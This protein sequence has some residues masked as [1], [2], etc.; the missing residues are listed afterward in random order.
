MDGAD[1]L[2]LFYPGPENASSP[3]FLSWLPRVAHGSVLITTRNRAVALNLV[4]S[5]TEPNVIY[6]LD[7][8][9]PEEAVQLLK[10]KIPESLWD[11]D[12]GYA[13]VKELE[14]I[15]LAISHAAAYIDYSVEFLEEYL[16]KIR[17]LQEQPSSLVEIHDS[18][19]EDDASSSVVATWQT[20]LDQIRVTSETAAELLCLMSAFDN[21]NIPEFFIA[22]PMA[23]GYV[24]S[25]GG[26]DP[27]AQKYIDKYGDKTNRPGA[28]QRTDTTDSLD[29]RR[30]ANPSFFQN[31][32][33]LSDLVR[34]SDQR[35]RDDILLLY[36]YGMISIDKPGNIYSMHSLVQTAITKWLESGGKTAYTLQDYRDRALIEVSMA[37]KLEGIP[38]IYDRVALHQNAAKVLEYQVSHNVM[39]LHRAEVLYHQAL[40]LRSTAQLELA[41][42]F[43]KEVTDIRRKYSLGYTL[44]V[45][46]ALEIHGGICFDLRRFDDAVDIF[47]D[48]L[49]GFSLSMGFS[50]S[51]KNNIA[52]NLAVSL[53]SLNRLEESKILIEDVIRSE[54]D[55]LGDDTTLI[56]EHRRI[57]A[58]LYKNMGEHERAI[59]ELRDVV[60]MWERRTDFWGVDIDAMITCKYELIG[61]LRKAG[62]NGEAERFAEG[63]VPTAKA[64]LGEGHTTTV[65]L[66]LS[67]S[68]ILRALEKPQ[69]A[70]A[71]LRDAYAQCLLAMETRNPVRQS[72]TFELIDVLHVRGKHSDIVGLEGLLEMDAVPQ[73]NHLKSEYWMSK[74]HCAYALH[75]VDKFEEAKVVYEVALAG[76]EADAENEYDTLD[77]WKL[78]HAACLEDL[79]MYK[80]CITA[81]DALEHWLNSQETNQGTW[82]YQDSCDNLRRKAEE[83][84][85]AKQLV[86]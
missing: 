30:T 44:P 56:L 31:D 14:Y 17:A 50:R 29:V 12:N 58:D 21:E 23:V 45:V 4:G 40:Y 5:Q 68:R 19:R 2:S 61:V 81:L 51:L 42:T 39:C 78:D 59:N 18:R 77:F 33:I 32:A 38:N 80:E 36:N 16:G 37:F 70:E 22:K 46:K 48:A 35:L 72:V 49:D 82:V 15:P 73:T 64:E 34:Q 75:F 62:Q 60:A 3:H 52:I 13:I 9:T 57:L 83:G 27:V 84:L 63:L 24:D 28:L 7:S 8:M 11:K 6:P 66:Q 67:Y 10:S 86:L 26:I 43:I 25:L 79:H 55:I 76:M 69:D 71:V 47:R 53:M 41:E 54:R 65:M 1:E 20:S 85:K 74:V